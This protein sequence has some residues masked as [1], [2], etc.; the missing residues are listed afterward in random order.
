MKEKFSFNIYILF[1]LVGATGTVLYLC[2]DEHTATPLLFYLIMFG[3]ILTIN[4]LFVKCKNEY[5]SD[6]KLISL[7]VFFVNIIVVILIYYWL[8][9]EVGI[10]YLAP[11]LWQDDWEFEYWARLAYS[12]SSSLNYF[13]FIDYIPKG[14]HEGYFYVVGIVMHI[15]DMLGGYHTIMPR[16]LN[17]FL[18]SISCV[19]TYLIGRQLSLP[20]RPVI[21]GA[22]M[23]GIFPNSMYFSAVILR[24][25]ISMVLVLT[26]LLIHIKS[27]KWHG[28]KLTMAFA[29]MAVLCL[30]LWHIRMYTVLAYMAFYVISI[31]FVSMK[32]RNVA[33]NIM[34]TML[35]FTIILVV[36]GNT[37]MSI[38]EVGLDSMDRY[39]YQ[40]FV[41]G[42]SGLASRLAAFPMPFN[43]LFKFIY[44]MVAP[45]PLT[46]KVVFFLKDS[47][48][49][50]WWFLLPF[51]LRFSWQMWRGREL[52]LILVIYWIIFLMGTTFTTFQT[53][54][55]LHWY[56]AAFLLGTSGYYQFK[57]KRSVYLIGQLGILMLGLIT[58][59]ILKSIL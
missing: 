7:S 39:N 58:Y 16:F 42:E 46:E 54:H 20:T 25:D 13:V 45:L 24:E 11:G 8:K 1:G 15:G 50:I 51:A 33:G 40:R 59:V 32:R 43:Y 17:S 37:I 53:R 28:V 35:V 30:F 47:G 19:L 52:T 14:A 48:F 23:V 36:A 26:L 29:V 4:Q 31:L 3:M 2:V 55:F 49:F 9:A 57:N 22:L 18:L 38:S 27:L 44:G 34:I 5:Y 6:L 56:P 12:S 21:L 41:S 10:P